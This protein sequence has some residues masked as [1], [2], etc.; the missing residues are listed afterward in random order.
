MP[1]LW[2]LTLWDEKQ[3]LDYSHIPAGTS[4]LIA[5]I[6][7]FILQQQFLKR[8]FLR[9]EEHIKASESHTILS[10]TDI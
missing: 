7:N 1:G 8:H 5:Y 10:Q 6:I 9:H 3:T 2:F 4:L